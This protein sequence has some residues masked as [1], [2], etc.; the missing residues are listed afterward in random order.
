[1]LVDAPDAGF[2]PW[3]AEVMTEA[4]KTE[5]GDP[6]APAS[7]DPEHV[8]STTAFGQLSRLPTLGDRPMMV[9]THDPTHPDGVESAFSGVV[10]REETR[11]AWLRAQSRWTGF[12]DISELVTVDGT[13]HL[14]QTQDPDAVVAAIL[15]TMDAAH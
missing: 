7:G 4:D 15:A 11:E 10:P 3:L 6:F 5:F 9:L 8:D 2:N 14:I 1:V 12:S 13:G